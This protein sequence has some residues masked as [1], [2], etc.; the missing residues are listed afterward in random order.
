M[1]DL[2]IT[3]AVLDLHSSGLSTRKI[4]EELGIGKSSVSRIIIE[5][6][7]NRPGTAQNNVPEQFGAPTHSVQDT[8]GTTEDDDYGT[9]SIS[10]QSAPGTYLVPKLVRIKHEKFEEF[11]NNEIEYLTLDLQLHIKEIIH[12]FTEFPYGTKPQASRYNDRT[13]ILIDRLVNISEHFSIRY[14]KLTYYRI[15]SVIENQ[16]ESVLNR[17]REPY[18]SLIFPVMRN[19]AA[20]WTIA[21]QE[22]IFHPFQIES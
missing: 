17:F 16:L 10:Y 22:D 7:E 18:G 19:E 13:S 11:F 15:L 2:E 6:K 3:E 5:N 9:D 1:K 21:L 12:V 8:S 14:H 4:A 20:Q